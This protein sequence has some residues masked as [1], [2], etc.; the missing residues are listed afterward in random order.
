MGLEI[1]RADFGAHVSFDPMKGRAI[2]LAFVVFFLVSGTAEALTISR[3]TARATSST[4]SYKVYYC[5]GRARVHQHYDFFALDRPSG[6]FTDDEVFSIG[7]GC[8]VTSGH[9]RNRYLP[10]LWELQLTMSD[11]RGALLRRSTRVFLR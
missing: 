2:G 8:Y 3:F 6:D 10:G 1:L 4:V 7:G 11:S 9:F 5:D